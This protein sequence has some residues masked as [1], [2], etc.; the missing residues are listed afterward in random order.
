MEI[1][2]YSADLTVAILFP[3]NWLL[4]WLGFFNERI[5]E[6]RKREQREQ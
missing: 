3:F 2:C 1:S 4:Q 5:N 6:K